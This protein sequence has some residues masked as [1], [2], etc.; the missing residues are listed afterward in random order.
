MM[1]V[2]ALIGSHASYV[3]AQDVI[4]V[5]LLG[6]QSNMLG[7]ANIDSSDPLLVNDINNGGIA[8]NDI[9]YHHNYRGSQTLAAN[10]FAALGPR[11][12][13]DGQSGNFGPELTFGRDMQIA[14]GEETLALLKYAVGGTSLYGDWFADGTASQSS[15]GP[16]Y[17]QFKQLVNEGLARL[18][19]DH[20]GA[21]INVAGM[22]WHQ[23]EADVGTQ[24]Y[25][26]ETNLTHFIHD[27]RQD[28][29]LPNLPFYIG[30]LSDTQKPY[31]D[32]QGRLAAFNV[33]VQ[34]QKNVAAADPYSWFVSL[35]AADGMTVDAG[36]LHF[37]VNGYKVMGQRFA[38][39]AIQQPGE[40]PIIPAVLAEDFEGQTQGALSD[41]A[42]IGDFQ[43]AIASGASG[44]ISVSPFVGGG[45]NALSYN[46]A[47]GSAVSLSNAV[48]ADVAGDFVVEFDLNLS[49]AHTSGTGSAFLKLYGDMPDDSVAEIVRLYYK[50]NG[51]ATQTWLVTYDGTSTF[52]DYSYLQ[53]GDN[54]HITITSDLSSNSYD[55]SVTL[56]DDTVLTL[57]TGQNF[58]SGGAGAIGLHSIAVGDLHGTN[59]DGIIDN[60]AVSSLWIPGDANGDGMVNLA[61]LQ[62]LG[63]NWQSTTATWAQADF[64]GDGVVNLADL[65]IVGDN[66]G[67]GTGADQAFAPA[68]EL[69]GVVVPEPSAAGLLGLASLLMLRRSRCLVEFLAAR[70]EQS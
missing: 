63:D 67:W 66:W 21:Q 15:D 23:G 39:T 68:L 25:N 44:S 16:Q 50:M 51:A 29:N 47:T 52:T 69:L 65:Q 56:D 49:R 1:L 64:T 7:R 4:N 20:P 40:P 61:D 46:G 43:A 24:A 53:L 17:I 59:M 13:D 36:G 42:V 32:A 41:G 27:V 19:T 14:L 58:F 54:A 31:Y 10:G 60:I 8:S 12:S 62:I 70:G 55:V 30:G 33:L 5:F 35:D 57:Y 28:L 48:G 26:Y 22:L 18:Q 6:G 38:T 45:S 2:A 3:C 37:D 11:P 34:A 9:L